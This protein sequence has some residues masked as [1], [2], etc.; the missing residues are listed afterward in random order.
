MSATDETALAVAGLSHRFGRRTVLDGVA[1]TVA[2]GSFTVLLG[3]N[4]AGKTTLFALITRLYHAA[5]GRI[6]VFGRDFRD[7]PQAALARMGVVFQQPTL[8]LDLTVEQNLRYHAALHG[9]A[10]AAAAPRI[11]AELERVGLLDRR[12]ERVRQLSGGQKRR[13]EL[14]RALVHEP[15]L[16]L[17]DEP[18]AGLDFESR[19]FLLGHVR[20]L[21][22]ERGLAVLWATHLIEEAAGEADLVVLRAGKVV[23]QGRVADIVADSGATGLQEAFEMMLRAA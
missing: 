10:A 5:S 2:R 18:T 14:A 22:A 6:A 8:D 11:A 15:A 19:R 4:G 7:H 12:G 1:F 16:L 21:C 20:Q 9:M 23:A 13:V 3:P 17:L